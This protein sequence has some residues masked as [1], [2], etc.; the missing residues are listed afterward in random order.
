MKLSPLQLSRQVLTKLNIEAIHDGDPN[1]GPDVATTVDANPTKDN[2]REW[3]VFLNVELKSPAG[4]KA[5]YTGHID[6]VGLFRIN[7]QWPA[8]KIEK[9]VRV[10]G[11]SIL[12]G[13]A[14][15][16]VANLTARG[17]W[18]MV[19]LPTLSFFTPA[20]EPAPQR[21]VTP[22]TSREATKAT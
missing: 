2:P 4:K 9:L 10:N 11:P 19:M 1:V 6:L 15:E 22:E 18:P 7:D 17:P 5:S 20:N 12:Y 16:L 14:R 3:I 13:A 8:E 21:Q